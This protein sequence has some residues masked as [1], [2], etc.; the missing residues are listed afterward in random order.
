MS[1]D[2][3]KSYSLRKHGNLPF[4]QGLVDKP[5]KP[6]FQI[7]S[8]SGVDRTTDSGVG[9]SVISPEITSDESD[10]DSPSKN[11]TKL[12]NQT[13]DQIEVIV[14]VDPEPI[15]NRQVVD[16]PID[17]RDLN[18]VANAILIPV[19]REENFE[20]DN[21]AL[22]AN[23]HI[24]LSDA[25]SF[26]P[27]FDGNSNE[28]LEFLNCCKEAKSVLPDGAEANL[29]KL[30]YG[31]KLSA[32][33][34]TS[35]NSVIPATI[36]ELT[37]KLK[38]I[39]IPNKS[40][41]QLQGELGRI[42]Q[43][44][45]EP[46]IEFVNRLRKKGHEIVECHKAENPD[47]TAAALGEFKTKIDSSIANCFMQNLVNEIDQRM[48]VCNT[49]EDALTNAMKIEKKLKVRKE[50]HRDLNAEHKKEFKKIE[51]HPN[52]DRP[53]NFVA[54]NSTAGNSNARQTNTNNNFKNNKTNNGDTYGACR[55]CGKPGHFAKN[56]TNLSCQI[57][58]TPGHIAKTC[59]QLNPNLN[60]YANVECQ[61][62]G[63][64]GHSARYCNRNP[65]AK[66]LPKQTARINGNV[67]KNSEKYCSL[68]KTST[69]NT[70]ECNV[71]NK[72]SQ[73]TT[74]FPRDG[75]RNNRPTQPVNLT[76]E[77]TFDDS[78]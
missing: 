7:T 13:A 48:P 64:K 12:I 74:S 55:K 52:N 23:Q 53:V 20:E 62:C 46:V 30:I 72:Q 1:N 34:K 50:L 18:P 39:Y 24:S 9:R 54:N 78:E 4:P 67:T 21:M 49:V 15:D 31:I 22:P 51:R 42:Y 70:S 27:K 25:L 75:G 40:L 33:I 29:T 16:P 77:V 66:S 45:N 68:H 6:R 17:N 73:A 28:L 61:L 58:F 59:P 65:N 43:K 76:Q 37:T 41:F 8:P 38:Q 47:A 56:C 19:L 63:N 35:L 14:P 60:K 32:K 69:H 57:C 36:T 5:R 11:K 3:N 26:V 2:E 10:T 44:E 71:L